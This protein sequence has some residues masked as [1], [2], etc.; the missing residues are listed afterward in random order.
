MKIYARNMLCVLLTPERQN[1]R[2]KSIISMWPR[3]KNNTFHLIIMM[4]S[5]MTLLNSLPFSRSL[6]SLPEKKPSALSTSLVSALLHWRQT[7]LSKKN[8]SFSV[9]FFLNVFFLLNSLAIPPKKSK[10]KRPV[11]LW[12]M[13]QFF[14]SAIFFH[15]PL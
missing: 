11:D 6:P 4:S 13:N 2:R 10:T 3:R 15:V 8:S 12:C 1:R 9:D 14:L 5:S 7:S